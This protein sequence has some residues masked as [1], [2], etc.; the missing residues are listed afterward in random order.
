MN[1]LAKVDNQKKKNKAKKIRQCNKCGSTD[2]LR[3]LSKN[4]KYYKARKK[5]LSE[6]SPLYI[7]A[8]ACTRVDKNAQ[9]FTKMHNNAQ[10]CTKIQKKTKRY[11]KI[12]KNAQDYSRIRK[13]TQEHTKMHK[14]AQQ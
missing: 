4:C 14:N 12:Y 11:S 7:F 3:S 10:A 6:R 13:N 8:D 1:W 5:R 2:R 9:A